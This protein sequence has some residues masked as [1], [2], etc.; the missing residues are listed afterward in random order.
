VRAGARSPKCNSLL[1]AH[2]PA[3]AGAR[4]TI[5]STIAIAMTNAITHDQRQGEA[6]LTRALPPGLDRRRAARRTLARE[7]AQHRA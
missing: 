1:R 5:T 7:A 4:P 3:C 2:A 6:S